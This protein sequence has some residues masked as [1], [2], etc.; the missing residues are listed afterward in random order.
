MAMRA[1]SSG[2]TI[3]T[4]TSPSGPAGFTAGS[5][6]SVSLD[7]PLISFNVSNHSSS[8]QALQ[9]TESVVI[10]FLAADQ[11]HLAQ[12]FSAAA[13]ERFADTESWSLLDTG[14]PLLTGTATWLRATIEQRIP[15]G[16]HTIVLGLV[17]HVCLPAPSTSAPDPLVYHDGKYHRPHPLQS[18][19]LQTGRATVGAHQPPAV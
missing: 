9:D 3:V 17:G 18:E 5:V 14:E 11:L 13:S 6:V 10:H 7:P 19:H 12:R 8:R 2:V 4:T 15:A 1:Y 16:D